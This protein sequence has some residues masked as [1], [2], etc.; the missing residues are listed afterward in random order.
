MSLGAPRSNTSTE[1]KEKERKV[2]NKDHNMSGVS[3]PHTS[4][5]PEISRFTVSVVLFREFL[6]C[7]SEPFRCART[8]GAAATLRLNS[9]GPEA[10]W[11][12]RNGR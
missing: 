10:L 9:R 8:L 2:K 3:H 1:D 7:R 11:C 12:R 6:S 5:A 4:T